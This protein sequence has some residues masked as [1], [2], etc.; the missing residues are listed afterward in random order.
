MKNLSRTLRFAA[1]ISFL[2]A[3]AVP[4]AFAWGSDGHRMIVH[5]AAATLPP[6]VPAFLKTPQAIATLEYMTVEP[7][8][9]WRQSDAEPELVA[10]QAPEHFISL[11]WTDLLGPLPRERYDY[12]RALD[13]AQKT[14]PD[15]AADFTPEKAGLQPYVTNE[16]WERLKAAFR[17]YRTET[18]AKQD[19][20]I[21]ESTIIFY[22]GWL[23]HYV[24]DGSQPLHTTIQYNGWNGP[25]PN[26]YTT[27][28][29]IHSAFET[30]YVHANIVR[31][32]FQS[33]IPVQP[34]VIGDEFDD[35][36]AYLR[37][38]NSY[39]E[40]TYQLYKA[41]AFTGAGTPEGK[42]FTTERLAAGAAQ[43]RDMIVAAWVQSAQ[44]V[45]VYV[46]PNASVPRPPETAK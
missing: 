44:P 19:T 41:G 38:T 33:Q 4:Q 28:H 12:I 30:A 16:V 8:E 9:R 20:R 5:A 11:E 14:H 34:R 10:A 27:D 46:N 18:A 2:P 3:L 26:G 45:R 23:S 39:V 21:V 36:L 7:D 15:M 40:K 35:Y 31:G 25:N 13:A 32:D 17:E 6:D 24:G 43:L 29:K 22:T 1:A 37:H 42:A